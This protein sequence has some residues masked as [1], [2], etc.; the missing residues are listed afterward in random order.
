MLTPGSLPIR[1][2]QGIWRWGGQRSSLFIAAYCSRDANRLP[3]EPRR[4][5]SVFLAR[6]E[7]LDHVNVSNTAAEPR[8]S[9]WLIV[10]IQYFVKINSI[11]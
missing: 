9:A 5:E 7:D 11:P 1:S 2:Y 10:G 4:S 8:H 6:L 3:W